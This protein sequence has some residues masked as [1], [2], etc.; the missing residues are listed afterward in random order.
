MIIFITVYFIGVVG[1]LIGNYFAEE[2]PSMLWAFIWPIMI[3]VFILAL[4]FIVIM[5]REGFLVEDA[6]DFT[7]AY[8]DDQ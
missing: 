5:K 6:S 3:V 4:L 1:W 8:R 7:D 2:P